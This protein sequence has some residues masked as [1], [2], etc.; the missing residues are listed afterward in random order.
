M[1]CIMI[2]MVGGMV[3][4][5]LHQDMGCGELLGGELPTNRGCGLQPQWFTWDKERV[6]PLQSLGW[7]NPLTSRGMNNQVGDTKT[8][9]KGS[10]MVETHGNPW[11][12]RWWTRENARHMWSFPEVG[13]PLNHLF[14]YR[15]CHDKQTSYWWYLHLSK[16]PIWLDVI[17]KQFCWLV[18]LTILKKT[19]LKPP[20][21]YIIK[22]NIYIYYLNP[23]H[24]NITVI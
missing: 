10:W 23:L 20:T 16:P 6:N 21:R 7:T 14:K 15:I 24:G 9:N 5:G 19:C 12:M 13:V 11:Q 4:G 8:P 17:H 3:V 1:I 18:V 22:W 2:S